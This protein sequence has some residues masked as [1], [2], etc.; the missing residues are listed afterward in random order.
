MALNV[1]LSG[2]ISG[3]LT[4]GVR[5]HPEFSYLAEWRRTARAFPL[6]LSLPLAGDVNSSD[7]VAAVLWGLLP[8]NE[9]LL[10][11]WASQFHVSARNPVGILGHVGE[12]CAGAVQFVRDERLNAV[13]AGEDDLLEPL[14][15][16]QVGE[17]LSRIGI[18][19]PASRQPTD[20]GQFSLA[21]AQAKIALLRQE[22]GSWAIPSGRID[23]D[24]PH[25]KA[26]E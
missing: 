8:D 5:G 25:T 7:K 3:R 22:D 24:N 20:V 14:T 21:G 1:L 4:Q 15:N 11:R 16:Q 6:S 17:R 18:G 13:L 2:Q 26:T 19:Q 23:S 12:D 10:Q 9:S